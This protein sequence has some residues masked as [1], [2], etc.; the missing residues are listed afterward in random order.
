[1]LMNA[2]RIG[3]LAAALALLIGNA[4]QA[5]LLVNGDFSSGLAG[6]TTWVQRNDGGNF[7]VAA[8]GGFLEQRGN[9]YNGGVY[10]V[11]AVPTNIPLTLTGGWQSNPTVA[12]EQ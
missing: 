9:S 4:A 6:W 12:S 10:Q 7:S 2:A 3:A 8:N 5:E 1:M 11:V